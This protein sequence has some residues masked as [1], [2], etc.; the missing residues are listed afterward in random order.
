MCSHAPGAGPPALGHQD[1]ELV[2]GVGFKTRHSVSQCGGIS[3]LK[4]TNQRQ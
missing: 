3:H 4:L 1:R 2:Q